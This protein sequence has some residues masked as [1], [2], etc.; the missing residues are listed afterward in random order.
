VSRAVVVRACAKINLSLRVGPARADGYHDVQTLL[1]SIALADTLT[2]TPRRGPFVLRSHAPNVPGDQ[3]NLVWRA[4]RA[5]WRAIGRDGEPRDVHVR[6]DKMIPSGAGLGGGSAD[7][8]ATLI[9]LNRLWQARLGPDV[10]TALGA[11]LGSDVPFFFIG[12]TAFAVGRGE[13]VYPVED[14]ARLGVLMLKPSFDVATPE[15]YRWLDDDRLA[16][17][18]PGT[19]QT[20]HLGWPTGA[21]SLQN[22][23]ERPVARRHPEIDEMIEGCRR[24]GA[25]VAA[26][27]G[28]GSAVFGVFREAVAPKAAR[29]LARPAWWVHLT[30]TL[31]RREALRHLGAGA[32][33]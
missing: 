19:P 5:L 16:G 24:Q 14:G 4:A 32:V 30:R 26:M 7:A 11:G 22:D 3:T 1:Q 25:I 9:A 18:A 33:W 10:L 31:S 27:T 17:L 29:A 15:A 20:L 2:I 21:V 8:A 23:L 12:G 13:E 6:L 28:S